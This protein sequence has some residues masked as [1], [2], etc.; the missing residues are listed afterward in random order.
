METL[1]PFFIIL[2]AGFFFSE[3]FNRLHLPWVIALMISGYLI[4]PGG[5]GIIEVSPVFEFL[6]NMGLIFVMFMAG[7]EAD[8]FHQTRQKYFGKAFAIGIIGALFSWIFGVLIAVALGLSLFAGVLLGIILIS[9]SMAITMPILEGN[10]LIEKKIGKTILSV[11]VIQDVLCLVLFSFFSHF[12]LGEQ[13]LSPFI[14][15]PILIALLF[16]LRKGI[17]LVRSYFVKEFHKEDKDIFEQ[18]LRAVLVLLIGIVA[19]FSV[20]GVH[21]ILAAFLA[22]M[23]LTDLIS[24]RDIRKDIHAF[25]YGLFI[26]I[27]FASVGMTTDFSAIDLTQSGFIAS[28]VILVLGVITIKAVTGYFGGRLLKI[29]HS[30]SL[31]LGSSVVPQLSTGLA[32][33]FVGRQAGLFDDTLVALFVLLTIVSAVVAPFLMKMSINS[34]KNKK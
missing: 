12:A 7:I 20:L 2:F 15:Y 3:F 8:F 16:L 26:P 22:G 19:L 34:L 25:G 14:I 6:S 28:V 21:E 24:H 17:P 5:F 27:F 31:V 23:I 13:S 32:L 1:F 11:M 4:G 30:E 9:S 29:S 33:V 10:G 18:E